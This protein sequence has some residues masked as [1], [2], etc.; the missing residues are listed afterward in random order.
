MVFDNPPYI[1]ACLGGRHDEAESLRRSALHGT[2]ASRADHVSYPPEINAGEADGL[3]QFAL[4]HCLPWRPATTR[5]KASGVPPY[6][7]QE[8]SYETGH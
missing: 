3:R 1:I 2:V 4:H 5:R 6:M 7:A 8:P